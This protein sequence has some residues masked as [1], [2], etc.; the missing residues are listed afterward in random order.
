MQSLG[1]PRLRIVLDAD[2]NG[3]I[4]GAEPTID[5]P[6]AVSIDMP[7]NDAVF[8]DGDVNFVG[9]IEIEASASD[10]YG[11]MQVEFV[12]TDS[13]NN[14]VF[15]FLDSD[16]SDGWSANWELA[17]VAD[18]N[19]T[20]VA[21]GNYTLTATATDTIDQTASHSIVVT[22][23]NETGDPMHIGDLDAITASGK[24]GKWDAMVTMTVHDASEYWVADALVDPGAK[25]VA[26]VINRDASLTVDDVTRI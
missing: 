25:I 10:D 20:L 6:P 11:V 2:N 26:R 5:L 9:S 3:L 14:I 1:T 7:A 13:E 15:S 12:V 23:D 8:G 21:D 16:D 18:G 24:G 22:V 4:C 17:D 19:Y